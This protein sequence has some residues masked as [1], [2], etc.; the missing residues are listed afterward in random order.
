MFGFKNL[1]CF[2]LYLSHNFYVNRNVFVWAVFNS[3]INFSICDAVPPLGIT[4]FN[5]TSSDDITTPRRTI[6]S[7]Q[8]NYVFFNFLRF[9]K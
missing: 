8:L 4:I 2:H 7:R 3:L 9:H 6:E 5:T 1:T